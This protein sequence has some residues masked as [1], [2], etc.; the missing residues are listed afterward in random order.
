M[1][2]ELIFGDVK[3]RFKRCTDIN[4]NIERGV[5]IVVTFC[6]LHNICI[7][8]GDL[9]YGG[10]IDPNEIHCNVNPN[11]NH[12]VPNNRAGERKRQII[13]ESLQ[14]RMPV[15]AFRRNVR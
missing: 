12:H 13:C 7:Q 15:I 8:Q 4:C 10:N 1:V 11:R 2:I 3:N 14:T 6:V 5:E 9:F